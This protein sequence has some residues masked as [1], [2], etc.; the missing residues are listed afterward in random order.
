MTISEVLDG[1]VAAHGDIVPDITR[2]ARGDGSDDGGDSDGD[3]GLE[4]DG[5][6][7]REPSVAVA[8]ASVLPGSDGGSS[9]PSGKRLSSQARGEG[10]S[11]KRK[12]AGR[13]EALVPRG[14]HSYA[15][16]HGGSSGTSVQKEVG[17]SS[18]SSVHGRSG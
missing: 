3:E 10:F 16:A 15:S 1:L 8:N 18:S 14:R 5:D 9:G 13:G 6:D 7:A 4:A 11:T 12:S 2:N 17:T